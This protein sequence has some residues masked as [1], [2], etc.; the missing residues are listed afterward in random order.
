MG[1]FLM[2]EQE[3]EKLQVNADFL[4]EQERDDKAISEYEAQEEV[5]K[6][7]DIPR[8][9]IKSVKKGF[10]KSFIFLGRAGTGKTYLAEE[11]LKGKKAKFTGGTIT[12]LSLY[13]F[14]YENNK[15]NMVLVFDDTA[16]LMK[17]TN[18]YA[19]LLGV[20]ANGKASWDSTTGKLKNIPLE[21]DF[22]GGIIF[23]ANKLIC[24][25][26][27]AI[28]SRSL[29]YE[30]EFTYEE[31]INMM[32]NIAEKEGGVDIVDFIKENTDRSTINLNLRTQQHIKNLKRYNKNWKEIAKGLLNKNEELSLLISCLKK[33][34]MI[35]QAERE[36]CDKTGKSR[37]TFYRYKQFLEV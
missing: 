3:A 27:E 15:K 18:A 13:K 25:N 32:Y 17:S 30:I 7:Y 33:Y 2:R 22:K 35:Y 23:I 5:L 34:N 14:L 21:F 20:L 12:P 31:M 10:H 16:G 19:L 1:V 24:E 37:R 26:E 11:T 4:Y 28:R 9:F 29:V 36:F 8:H 6:K